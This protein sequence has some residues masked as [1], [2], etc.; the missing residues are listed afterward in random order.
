VA[1]RLAAA[2]A[3]GMA[4]ELRRLQGV[5]SGSL[6]RQAGWSGAAE[7]A[8]QDSVSAEV[9]WFAPAVRRYEGY[10]AALAGYAREL[11]R[12]A[13]GLR[14]ARARLAAGTDPAAAAA[15]SAEFERCWQQWDA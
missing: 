11:D 12:L 7:L 6:G 1:V 10:A 5:L 9:A 13:P 4:A 14:A 3:A 15:W 2:R 8:F